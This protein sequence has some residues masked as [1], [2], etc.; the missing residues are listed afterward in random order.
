MFSHQQS[1]LTQ[2]QTNFTV[3][4]SQYDMLYQVNN[5][6]HK[7]AGGLY[8]EIYKFMVYNFTYRTPTH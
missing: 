1:L 2:I 3:F 6:K 8:R 4:T 5:T 7:T